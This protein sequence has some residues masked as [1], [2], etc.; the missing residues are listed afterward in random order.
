MSADDDTVS[1]RLLRPR[2]LIDITLEAPKCHLESSAG[3]RHLVADAE[4]VLILHLPPQHIAETALQEGAP[5]TDE[6]V[7]HRAAQPSRLVYLLPAGTQIAYTL[8]GILEATTTLTLSVSPNAIPGPGPGR[9]A[10]P[11]GIPPTPPDADQT[12]LEV[13]YRLVVS[14]NASARF[15]TVA[16]PRARGGS[17]GLWRAR[18]DV[19]PDED[20]S[21]DETLR[22]VRAL[23]TPGPVTDPGVS[24]SWGTTPLTPFDRHQIV[25]QTCATDQRGV[26]APLQVADLALSSLGAW[27]DWTG[28]WTD[29]DPLSDYRHIAAMGRDNY[30]RVAYPGYLFPFGHRA[31]LVKISER[32]VVPSATGGTRPPR[33]RLWQRQFI[34]IREHQ[35]SYDTVT[36]PFISVELAPQVT[37]DLDLPANQD[38]FAPTR[39]GVA[40]LFT[41]NA[42]DKAGGR[43]KFTAPLIFVGNE[44]NVSVDMLNDIYT[45]APGGPIGPLDLIPGNGQL[46]AMAS[47]SKAGDTSVEV[48]HLQFHVD[49]QN[50]EL[51]LSAVRGVVPAMRQ[52]A[53]QAPVV[54]MAYPSGYSGLPDSGGVPVPGNAGQLFMVLTSS[55]AAVDFSGGSDRSG[56]FISPSFPTQ[57]ISRSLGAVGDVG[58]SLGDGEFDPTAFFG[59]ALPKLFGLFSLLDLI[60]VDDIVDRALD[61]APQFL[62]HALD[63]KSLLLSSIGQL[64][65]AM[66]TAHDRLAT[67]VANPAHRGA[68]QIAQDALDAMDQRA[69][70]LADDASAIV[71][72]VG[73]LP[74]SAGTLSGQIDTFATDLDDLAS[75]LVGTPGIPAGVRATVQKPLDTLKGALPQIKTILGDVA[76]AQKLLDFANGLLNPGTSTATMNWAPTI[77][78][79]PQSGS[80]VNIFYP[81]NPQQTLNLAIQIQSSNTAPPV[82]DILA[83]MVDFQ[84]N[85]IGDG[86]AGLMQLPFQRIGF[87]AGSNGKTEVD[88]VF[89]DMKFLGVLG[90]VNTLRGIIPFDGFSDPPLVSVAPD[91]VTAGFDIGLPNVGIGVFSLENIS[92][93]ADAR[94]PFLGDAVTIG[95]HFCTKDSPFRLT[96][97]CIGGGGWVTLRASPKRMVLLDVGLEASAEL[98]IDLGVASGSVSIAVGV[99]LQL[100]DDDGKLTGY[101]RIRGQVDVLGLV[102]ASITLELSLSY[103]FHHGKAVGRA[104]IAVEVHVLFFSASVEV[105]CERRLAGSSGDPV[106]RDIMP[107]D[108]GGGSDAW[109]AYCGAFADE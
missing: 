77:K 49:P 83:E 86:N 63:P 8:E 46:V 61:R 14:P 39:N 71:S 7:L 74:G 19:R 100:T 108:S 57:G 34:V 93:G 64:D 33:A 90:F 69:S 45:K 80:V 38:L 20:G 84:L 94:V 54:D 59:A 82:I 16:N 17:S 32:R 66:S 96:V 25:A 60:D 26:N 13:P 30:V 31:V 68:Q 87:H 75:A 21:T 102:S 52:L 36:N 22:T 76:Q 2:D 72:S 37:P 78:S 18:L 85:L 62:R 3:V 101:F 67:E 11:T 73:D 6:L 50:D 53:P 105:T 24:D 88:V 65:D 44:A 92:L 89:G 91:G 103:D 5:D 42:V 29:E 43:K 109:T 28:V 12:A 97:M 79:W 4:T 51:T 15:V 70:R 35:R 99:Y 95:F 23:W 98:A 81:S 107:P 9:S 106:L 55:P 40:Y 104:T 41:L 47:E 56:G 27:F 58:S 10:Q 48:S 1:T